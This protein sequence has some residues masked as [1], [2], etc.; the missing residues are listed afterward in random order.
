MHRPDQSSGLRRGWI[1]APIQATGRWT[2]PMAKDTGR[3]QATE[4]TAVPVADGRALYTGDDT[5]GKQS[6]EHQMAV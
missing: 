4:P 3:G 5:T 2:V 1:P 6:A